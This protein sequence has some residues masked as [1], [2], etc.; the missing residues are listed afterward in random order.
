MPDLASPLFSL[1][2]SPSHQDTSSA[3]E[4]QAWQYH[5]YQAFM[6]QPDVFPSINTD[7]V[8]LQN[9]RPADLNST[10]HEISPAQSSEHQDQ[11]RSRSFA[12]NICGIRYPH[13]KS[14]RD[15]KQS[16][17]EGKRYACSVAGCKAIVAHKKNLKRHMETKHS[18]LETRPPPTS[19]CKPF[20]PRTKN[21]Q[22]FL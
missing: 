21:K 19:H 10:P 14:L 5:D 1:N 20:G 18:L 9:P 11:P 2:S 17:H 15:H 6:Y 7:H 16:K 13:A 22:H 4:P 8:E 12:C 3:S